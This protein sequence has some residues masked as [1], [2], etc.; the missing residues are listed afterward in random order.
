MARTKNICDKKNP[1][2][3][4]VPC[5]PEEEAYYDAKDAKFVADYPEMRMKGVRYIRTRLLKQ[6]DYSQAPDRPDN[7]SK[8]AWAEY[9]QK[10]RDITTV[11]ALGNPTG[12]ANADA[13][14]NSHDAKHRE[15]NPVDDGKWP[16]EP[17]V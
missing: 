6:S 14:H 12:L 3:I 17:G 9:R 2:G 8:T 7:A 15:G 13:L 10:L 5:T 1:N 11:D 4:S 16:T